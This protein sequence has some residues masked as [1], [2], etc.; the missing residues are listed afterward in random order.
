MDLVLRKMH[1]G[2][3]TAFNNL[4][5]ALPSFFFVKLSVDNQELVFG[6]LA[7][8]CNILMLGDEHCNWLTSLGFSLSQSYHRGKWV[9]FSWIVWWADL[10]LNKLWFY[11]LLVF[12]VSNGLLASCECFL[13]IIP[14][15]LPALDKI[16][17]LVSH[18]LLLSYWWSNYNEFNLIIKFFCVRL[19]AGKYF[20]SNSCFVLS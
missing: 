16:I 1:G 19:L 7:D 9:D 3:V 11:L 15:V 5:Q 8:L 18:G 10:G 4:I 6:S 14:L 12:A 20:G 17:G 13:F 2:V